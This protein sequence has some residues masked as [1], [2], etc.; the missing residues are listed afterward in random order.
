MDSNDTAIELFC[1]LKIYVAGRGSGIL[2]QPE[3]RTVCGGVGLWRRE[4]KDQC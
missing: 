3:H 1:Q 4:F 2:L